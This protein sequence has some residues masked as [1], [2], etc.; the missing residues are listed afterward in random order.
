MLVPKPFAAPHAPALLLPAALALL[1]SAARVE[2]RDL[3]AADAGTHD[4]AVG[5]AVVAAGDRAEPFLPRRVPLG[6]GDGANS[7]EGCIRSLQGLC[8]LH[9]CTLRQAAQSSL[10]SPT[11]F[12]THNLQLDDLAVQLHSPDFLRRARGPNRSARMAQDT[13]ERRAPRP[14]P[15]NAR[16]PWT[17]KV[18]TDSA[19]VA[20]C[21]GVVLAPGEGRSG[22]VACPAV[23][24]ARH[25]AAC[26]WLAPRCAA[27]RAPRAPTKL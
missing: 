21:V 10:A 14:N 13:T 6:W 12:P 3:A 22:A 15:P 4:N 16:N 2:T 8:G 20:L 24:A 25:A 7:R 5:A 1:C 23:S 9:T 26:P 19:D 27:Q 18:D 17:H 11:P